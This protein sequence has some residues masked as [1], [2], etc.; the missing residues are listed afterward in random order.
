MA[1]TESDR[2][3][4]APNSG[5]KPTDRPRA[6]SSFQDPVRLDRAARILQYALS[7]EGLTIADLCVPGVEHARAA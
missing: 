3:G 7:R 2:P 1:A 4:G 5:T 6:V